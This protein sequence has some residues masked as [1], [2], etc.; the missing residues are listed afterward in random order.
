MNSY[1]STE[2]GH[3]ES[4]IRSCKRFFND[5][6]NEE[7]FRDDNLK[8][9]FMTLENGVKVYEAFCRQF[10]PEYLEEN[11]TA[12]G[13]MESFTAQAFVNKDVYGILARL[14]T[15]IEFSWY[16]SWY[17]IILHEMSH[18]FCVVH[19]IGGE[20]FFEKY[21]EDK[22]EDST[23]N[24]LI[25]AG[26]AI[27][28]EFIADYIAAQI[29]PFFSPLSM[30]ELKKEVSE[31]DKEWN[32]TN[33]KAKTFVSQMLADILLNSKVR[34][35]KNSEAILQLLEKEKVFTSKV[36]GTS[37]SGMIRILYKQ[38]LQDEC[39]KINVD[40]ILKLG[41]EY[42]TQMTLRY[43]AAQMNFE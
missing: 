27:W 35:Q 34:Q 21:C 42:L 31:L 12:P 9:T 7:F 41:E 6:L 14:D 19:E 26:Y 17:E 36:P 5:T 16:D 15:G 20:N 43:I 25:C 33:P 28:R 24:G 13:Y 29:N 8:V 18:I 38:L 11:Y 30:R 2:K 23:R 4:V 1:N 40:F 37:Y 32:S 3:I 39:W 22:A 10:F